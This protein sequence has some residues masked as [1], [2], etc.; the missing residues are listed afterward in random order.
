MASPSGSTIKSHSSV[1]SI[2]LR[3]KTLQDSLFLV[4]K[5]E[6]FPIPEGE[7][8]SESQALDFVLDDLLSLKGDPHVKGVL[9]DMADSPDELFRIPVTDVANIE[10]PA[11]GP[12]TEQGVAE[13]EKVAS[14][15]VRK[16]KNFVHFFI[17][18]N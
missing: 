18:L 13:R 5:Q 14:K 16:F 10:V 1:K 3:D 11:N 9:K 8:W 12:T 7:V 6:E 15:V 17:F 4:P 2:Q